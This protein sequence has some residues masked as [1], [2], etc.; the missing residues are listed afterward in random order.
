MRTAS[1]SVGSGFAFAALLG[2]EPRYPQMRI[3]EKLTPVGKAIADDFRTQCQTPA[4]FALPFL[5]L[6]TLFVGGADP[7]DIPDHID[8]DVTHVTIGH[9]LHVRDLKLPEGVTILDD[10]GATVCVCNAPKQ[11]VEATPGAEAEGAAAVAE[12]ELIRKTKA[13]EEEEE[14]EKKK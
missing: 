3:D 14:K 7:A 6:N 4:Y 2:L 12:P 9:G 5:P 8:V 11:V 1:G 13:E 10:P